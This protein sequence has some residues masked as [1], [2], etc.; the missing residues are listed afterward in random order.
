V[1]PIEVRLHLEREDGR[2]AERFVTGE[3]VALVLTVRNP[4]DQPWRL[5]LS[6][7]QSHDFAIGAPDGRELWRWSAGRRFAQQLGELALG[8]GEERLFRATWTPE[9]VGSPLPGRYRAAGWLGGGRARGPGAEFEFRVSARERAGAG[10]PHDLAARARVVP[11]ALR[12]GNDASAASASST[13]AS[14][15]SAESWKR[16][17]S[18]PRGTTG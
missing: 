5:P 10:L 13:S 17:S 1:P 15:W 9:H 16:I 14:V 7:S 6:S 11:H 3:P 2:A 4:G 12:P 8:P 18:S